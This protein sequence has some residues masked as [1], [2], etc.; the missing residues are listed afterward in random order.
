MAI[1]EKWK[2]ISIFGGLYQI[3]DFGRVKSLMCNKER[4]LKLKKQKNGYLGVSI[5]YQKNVYGFSVHRLVAEAFIPNP[6]NKPEVNH[7]FKIKDDNRA[8]EL[9]WVTSAEN[10]KHAYNTDLPYRE[11]SMVTLIKK[12]LVI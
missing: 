11:T 3:S 7:K 4:I 10:K 1:I 12:I 6:N 5:T 8:S 9:E 2:D